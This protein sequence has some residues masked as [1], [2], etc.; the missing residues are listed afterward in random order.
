[1]WSRSAE[2]VAQQ[3]NLTESEVKVLGPA[4]LLRLDAGD[5]ARLIENIQQTR[6]EGLSDDFMFDDCSIFVGGIGS[7]VLAGITLEQF[8]SMDQARQRMFVNHE[9]EIRLLRYAGFTFDKLNQLT[10]DQLQELLGKLVE[11]ESNHYSS[12]L[13]CRL[14][15][16][17]D[18]VP[19]QKG[20]AEVQDY[21]ADAVR[22]NKSIR[23]W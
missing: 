19:F 11:N 5:R 10:Q 7:L 20:V 2:S 23:P 13:R 14:T 4:A 1:M 16:K 17:R 12:L 3:F 21:I 8:A 22:A 9:S 15:F 6:E 18:I